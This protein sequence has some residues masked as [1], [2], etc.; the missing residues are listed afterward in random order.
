MMGNLKCLAPFGCSI[1]LGCRAACLDIILLFD[2]TVA[3]QSVAC[4]ALVREAV[5]AGAQRMTGEVAQMMAKMVTLGAA[6][7]NV[8][9]ID[10]SDI[11]GDWT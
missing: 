7:I 6:E 11:R 10:F 1:R 3:R 5:Q 8:A 9:A 2:L 4:A